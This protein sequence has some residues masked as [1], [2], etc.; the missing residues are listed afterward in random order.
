MISFRKHTLLQLLKVKRG[1]LILF[2]LATNKYTEPKV[3]FFNRFG[4]QLQQHP[5]P[6]LKI[7]STFGSE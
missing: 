2:G 5:E 4:S 6:N 3:A 7:L 1:F